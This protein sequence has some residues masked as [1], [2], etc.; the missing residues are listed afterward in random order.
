MCG[1]N[2]YGSDVIMPSYAARNSNVLQKAKEIKKHSYLH[3]LI[4]PP[5][6][7]LNCPPLFYIPS[8][9]YCSSSHLVNE[10]WATVFCEMCL[11]DLVFFLIF[12]FLGLMTEGRQNRVGKGGQTLPPHIFVT[13]LNLDHLSSQRH[14]NTSSK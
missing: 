3:I 9:V 11:D 6:K 4:N 2:F 14:L 7:L 12:S 5:K 1:S 8:L 13:F 10:K